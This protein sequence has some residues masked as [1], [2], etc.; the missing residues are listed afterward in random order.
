MTVDPT[1]SFPPD[2]RPQGFAFDDNGPG[3]VV[4]SDLMD[5]YMSAANAIAAATDL[6]KLVTC[7]PNA[8]K[9]GCAQAVMRSL[10]TRAFRRPVTDAEVARYAN[11]VTGPSDWNKGVRA[12]VAALLVAPSF[13]YR[14]EVGTKQ[15]DGSF[16]LDAYETASALSYFFWGSMPDQALFDAAK[17]GGL[18]TPDGLEKQARRLLADPRARDTV[19]AF[20]VQWLG[21]EP[22]T[23]VSKIDSAGF[24]P[25]I[26]AAMLEETRR[27]VTYV[28]FDGTHKADELFT[29]NYTF[30][31]QTLAGVYGISGVSG[32]SFVKTQY[33]DNLRAGVMGHGSVLATT[34]LSDQTS[35]I[36]RGLFVRRRLLCQEFGT[37]PPQAGSIPAVDPNATT[38]E[39]FAQHSANDFCKSCHQYIDDVGFGFERFDIVG[40]VRTMEAGQPIDSQGD[41]NDVEGFG[42][43]THAPFASLSDLGKTLA[44]S[45]AAKTCV[46]RQMYRFARGQIEKDVCAVDGPKQIFLQK[47]GDLQ[48]L[49]VAI[50]TAP[51]FVV[52]Q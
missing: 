36:R 39:R 16:R 12:G 48:E 7:D 40:K 11:V 2:T 14:S 45:D 30:A 27:F 19:G 49:M 51:D 22:V 47:G 44:Q 4:T 15:T 17:N 46:V 8:D 34:A 1:A 32:T 18:S 23:T 10:A 37:P 25:D 41:M 13:L 9:P 20:A 24:T 35:P 31:N 3:R 26:R 42:K 52:R 21:A 28:T 43:G 33:P 38:R 50:A 5:G 6:T 29:A